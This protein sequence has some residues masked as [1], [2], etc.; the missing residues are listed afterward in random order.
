M[1]VQFVR[2]PSHDYHFFNEWHF[3]RCFIAPANI[4]IC[5]ASSN[6]IIFSS[7]LLCVCVCIEI[8]NRNFYV[9]RSHYEKGKLKLPM[10]E[11]LAK[12]LSICGFDC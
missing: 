6:L 10:S 3:F 4:L 1:C 11:I 9:F 2:P 7:L 5:G 8:I 12:Q